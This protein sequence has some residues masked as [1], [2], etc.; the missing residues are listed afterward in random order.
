MS[1]SVGTVLK[2]TNVLSHLC[3]RDVIAALDIPG[4]SSGREFRMNVCPKCGP[5]SRDS[6][7]INLATGRWRCFAHQCKGDLLTFLALHAGLR[8]SDQFAEV[9]ALAQ[10]IA[11]TS[12]PSAP[13]VAARASRDRSAELERAKQEVPRLWDQ[14][15]E[16]SA[17]AATY[18]AA[19]GLALLVGRRDVVRGTPLP[20]VRSSSWHERVSTILSIPSVVV[21]SYDLEDGTMC[22]L[23][24]RRLQPGTRSK[25]MGLPAVPKTRG[26]GVPVGT[27]GRWCDYREKPRDVVLVEGVFDYLT[28]RQMFPDQLVLGVDGGDLLAGV[29]RQIATAI[30]RAGRSLLLVPHNDPAGETSIGAAVVV[31]VG[32]GLRLGRGL[33]ILDVTA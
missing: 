7:S 17:A 15:P 24:S 27:F 25:V 6:V 26:N 28:A 5:R 18:M 32:A 14:L 23:T 13:T 8:C 31:A 16:I 2:K 9:L 4:R 22:N 10:R 33:Q 19:R 3:A 20:A 21:P 1:S 12:G 11:G 29:V 30:H